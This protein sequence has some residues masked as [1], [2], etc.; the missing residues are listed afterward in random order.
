MSFEDI[1]G[2]E[3]AEVIQSVSGQVINLKNYQ[4]DLIE[5]G[6]KVLGKE[7]FF[8]VTNEELNIAFGYTGEGKYRMP[9]SLD[10]EVGSFLLSG[11]GDLTTN[12]FIS[13]D[14]PFSE[15]PAVFTSQLITGAFENNYD[16]IGR[17]ISTSGGFYVTGSSSSISNHV[18]IATKTGN[19]KFN[20]SQDRIEIATA[21]KDNNSGYNFVG[22]SE[23]FDSIPEVFI[24]S[25]QPQV[26]EENYFSETCIT[27]V[28]VSGFYFN[29]FQSD[30][31]PASGTGIFAYLATNQ[32]IFNVADSSDLPIRT[33]NYSCT[34]ESNFNFN[35]DS[36]LEQVNGTNNAGYRFNNDQYAVLYQRYGEDGLF[37][38][39]FFAVQSTG[40]G[41]NKV[42]EHI[43]QTGSGIGASGSIINA[44]FP[45]HVYSL[46]NTNGDVNQLVID[47][48]NDA[49]VTGSFTLAQINNGELLTFAAGGDIRVPKIYDHFG[50]KHAI[51]DITGI[52]A[53]IVTGGSMVSLD[54]KPA[55]DFVRTTGGQ[56]NAVYYRVSDSGHIT[57]V[58]G[59]EIFATVSFDN[60]SQTLNASNSFRADYVV[61][62]NQNSAVNDIGFGAGKV[63]GTPYQYLYE[64]HGSAN[65]FGG[66]DFP[67]DITKDGWGITGNEISFDTKYVLNGFVGFDDSATS[68]FR[69][70]TFDGSYVSGYTVS[71][72]KNN[73]IGTI[74][75][76]QTYDNSFD[77]KFQE[78]LIYKNVQPDSR[79]KIRKNALYRSNEGLTNPNFNFIQIGVTGIL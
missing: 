37:E 40:D 78:L 6:F 63:A 26:S 72:Q 17:V 34:G 67:G 68:G 44:D 43:L 19:F 66:F 60:V 25:Q 32:N 14:Q 2:N 70:M 49:N 50:D 46:F 10:F 13:F 16:K 69:G 77:G 15:S 79:E 3:G 30:L 64:E 12:Q 41:K 9:P 58:E 57:G 21:T 39:N 51:Q 74:G 31:S 35:T 1:F 36:I 18:Y 22:F 28:S 20:N 45:D 29:S 24:Q 38:N 7:E 48:A 59:L 55:L 73:I 65:T 52:Q 27:G 56:D 8:S 54:G 47:G 76:D 4:G 5:T 23:D 42:S 75:S 71:G 62:E 33:L 61:S 53:K 11:S